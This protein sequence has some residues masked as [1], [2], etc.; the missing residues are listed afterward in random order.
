MAAYV[1]GDSRAFREVFLRFA[2][3]LEAMARRRLGPGPDSDDLVQQ[4]FLQLHRA[5]HDFRPG[6]RLRP[7]LV[8]IAMNLARDLLRRRG[9]R[10][11]EPIDPERVEAPMRAGGGPEGADEARRVRAALARLPEDQREAVELFWLSG[12]SYA[13]IAQ[14]V[15]ATEGAVRVRAHR[16]YV[17]L[18]ALLSNEPEGEA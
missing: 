3:M 14:I 12:L 7:W 10:P 15:G 4:A 2:P 16:G 13:E 17:R 8:T 5:R 11:E 6:M 1:G 18:R 9:R